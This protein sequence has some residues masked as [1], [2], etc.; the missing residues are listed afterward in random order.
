M[1]FSQLA[2]L[3]PDKIDCFLLEN[4][5]RIGKNHPIQKSHPP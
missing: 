1:R 5:K 2:S 4:E 3:L